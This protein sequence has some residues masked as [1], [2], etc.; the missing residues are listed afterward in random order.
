MSAMVQSNQY[1]DY[2]SFLKQKQKEM[3][4]KDMQAMQEQAGSGQ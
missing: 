3:V 1:T 4:S 2:P